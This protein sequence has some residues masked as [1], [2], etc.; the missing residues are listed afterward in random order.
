MCSKNGIWKARLP[1]H[2]AQLFAQ[3]TMLSDAPIRL[4][5]KHCLHNAAAN[6]AV[7]W[8]AAHWA[9][10]RGGNKEPAPSRAKSHARPHNK[11]QELVQSTLR[12]Q[13]G[14]F[15]L[16]RS[17]TDASSMSAAHTSHRSTV[18]LYWTSVHDQIQAADHQ[19]ICSSSTRFT[20]D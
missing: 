9:H 13:G 6:S 12:A 19:A 5:E 16:Q 8:V 7:V 17:A 11:P 4:V 14:A 10:K 18:P 15:A 20:Q 2:K 1:D 3:M